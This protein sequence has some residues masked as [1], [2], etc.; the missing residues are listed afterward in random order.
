VNTWQR[1][2]APSRPR[3]PRALALLALGVALGCGSSRQ[4]R[5]P[6]AGGEPPREGARAN[7]AVPERSSGTAAQVIGGSATMS[8]PPTSPQA[9]GIIA[10]PP[11]PPPS[12]VSAP[13]GQGST[14]AGA[15]LPPS[16]AGASLSRIE[17]CLTARGESEARR[18][19]MA[20]PRRATVSVRA[21]PG[22]AVVVHEL[23]HA[24]CLRAKVSARLDGD[25]VVVTE[26]LVGTPCR[27]E[28][29]SV[30]RTGVG[31]PAGRHRVA[32]QVE[33]GDELTRVHDGTLEIR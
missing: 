31:L 16:R 7:A 2:A 11:E 28:C 3:P 10:V 22:G 17:G 13:E 21:A 25:L 14:G 18:Y 4:A 5:P 6:A 26:R 33:R 1:T 23:A 15:I 32:V 20:L 12:V 9:P 27:C 30:I 19:A 24:C 8:V 29:G